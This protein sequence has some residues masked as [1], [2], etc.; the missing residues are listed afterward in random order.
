MQAPSQVSTTTQSK[1]PNP[2]TTPPEWDQNKVSIS[3]GAE[4]QRSGLRE[5]NMRKPN[6]QAC[7]G[8]ISIMKRKNLDQVIQAESEKENRRS[9]M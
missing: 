5:R 6:I 7:K 9:A 1:C 2:K 3:W 8:Q 4:L